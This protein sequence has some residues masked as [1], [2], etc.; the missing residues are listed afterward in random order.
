MSQL[1]VDTHGHLTT[2]AQ[3]LHHR[4]EQNALSSSSSRALGLMSTKD[5]HNVY[6]CM[7]KQLDNL[8]EEVLK[9]FV[10]VTKHHSVPN[11]KIKKFKQAMT[12]KILSARMDMETEINRLC[13]GPSTKQ[14]Q[15]DYD[16]SSHESVA[17]HLKFSGNEKYHTSPERHARRK[18]TSG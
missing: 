4:L 13:S 15:I 10:Q 11:D 16:K 14:T 3:K 6:L 2:D 5:V 1:D 17:T 12:R 9:S 8:K 18:G 7:S